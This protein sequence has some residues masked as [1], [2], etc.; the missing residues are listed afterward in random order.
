MIDKNNLHELDTSELFVFDN[1]EETEKSNIQQYRDILKA[2]SLKEDDKY[3]YLILGIEN[4]T[5]IDYAMPVRVA[6]YDALR[7]HSQLREIKAK[8]REANNY[9][10]GDEFLS[11]FK[12]D[13]RLK[14]VITIVIYFGAKEYDGPKGLR[15]MYG[16]I[17][18]ELL[19]YTLDY[20]LNIIEPSLIKDEDI[21]NKFKSD[22]KDVLLFVK[23]SADKNKIYNLVHER[24]SF[25]DMDNTTVSLINEITNINIKINKEGKRMNMCKAMEDLLND[26]RDEGGMKKLYELVTEGIITISQAATNAKISE[27]EFKMQM[28]N[29]GF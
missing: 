11:A 8:N 14:P 9:A 23:Y 10:S 27:E 2:L 1:E 17:N 4:Q 7:Y 22:L 12:K 21:T 20:Q 3:T 29:A 13:D 16:N 28:K 25:S 5:Y 26:S 18:K 24:P 15:A 6:I 19:P